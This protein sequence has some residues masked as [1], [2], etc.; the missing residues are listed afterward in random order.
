[1][2]GIHGAGSSDS[3]VGFV[4]THHYLSS[5][6]SAVGLLHTGRLPALESC[7]NLLYLDLS[8]HALSGPLP[9]PP[10]ELQFLNL[11]SNGLSRKLPELSSSPHLQYI[12]LSFNR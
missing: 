9:A 8:G 5:Y 4:K 3:S 2:Q 7:K 12:D 1:M 11:S 6:F 10:T